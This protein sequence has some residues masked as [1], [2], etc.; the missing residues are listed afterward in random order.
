MFTFVL[1]S[2]IH[3]VDTNL[4]LWCRAQSWAKEDWEE[5]KRELRQENKGW[6]ENGRRGDRP[7][8]GGRIQAAYEKWI[9]RVHII[10]ILGK[11]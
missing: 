9:Q 2:T 4:Y 1:R 8:W 3:R 10:M 5:R 11:L 7:A 6:K